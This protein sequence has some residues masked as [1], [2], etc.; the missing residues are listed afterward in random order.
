M[1]SEF[2][3]ALPHVTAWWSVTPPGAGPKRILPDGCLDLIWQDGHVFVAGPD[4][5]A[6][7]GRPPPGSRMVA[8]RFG[9]G[10]GPGVLG[11]PASEVVDQRVP[12]DA[13]WPAA[14]V[15]ALAEAADPLAAL[16]AATRERW[17]SPDRAMV[18]LAEA[19]RAGRSVGAIA[20]DCGLSPRQ[21]QRRSH[22]AFGYGPKTLARVF[23]LERALRL[24]RSGT[25][26]ATVSAEAGYADQA[27]LARE[28]RALAGVPLGELLSPGP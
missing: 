8:L 5:I 10:T 13:L 12:L 19:A 27:H 20:D 15:R 22:T 3:S 1:Y 11:L 16:T 25:P 23:R 6:Q 4:T 9:S 7:V 17:Q 18:A 28:V 14:A 21:L 24:A 26:F 2:A